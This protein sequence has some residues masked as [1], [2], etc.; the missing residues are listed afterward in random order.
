M[1]DYPFVGATGRGAV[2]S[3]ANLGHG[4]CHLSLIRYCD[5]GRGVGKPD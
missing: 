4:W 2:N 3:L 1:S 5:A